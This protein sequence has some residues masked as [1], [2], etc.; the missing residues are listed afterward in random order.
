M[1]RP[2]S[3]KKSIRLT[4]TLEEGEYEAVCQFAK[5]NGA[6]AA[7]A[8][9]RAIHLSLHSEKAPVIEERGAEPSGFRRA[10]SW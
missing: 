2:K 9:R 1:A 7:W 10:S 4:V 5:A 6:S 8:I 3:D